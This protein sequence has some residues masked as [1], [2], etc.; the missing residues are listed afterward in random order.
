[1]LAIP[2]VVGITAGPTTPATTNLGNTG[3]T[4]NT[5]DPYN[6][7][8]NNNLLQGTNNL[9]VNDF[10][11]IAFTVR[12]NIDSDGAGGTPAG[13]GSYTNTAT[14]TGDSPSGTPVEDDSQNGPN[15]DPD[16]DDDPTNNDDPTP[17]NITE[18]PILGVAK[19]VGTVTDNGDG[20][21]NVPYI[22]RVQNY[23]NVE[24]SNVQVTDDL[25]N[26][27]VNPTA[28]QPI[29]NVIGGS[30]ASPT[31]TV[32]AGFN[33]TGDNNLL[34]GSDTL[35]VGATAT[36]TFTVRVE[37]NIAQGI[38]DN[39]AFGAGD[40]PGG[41]TVTDTSQD[42]NDPDDNSTDPAVNGDGDPSNNSDPTR[43]TI[44]SDPVIGVAKRV[45]GVDIDTPRWHIP[46]YLRHRRREPRSYSADQRA[47]PRQPQHHLR[48]NTFCQHRDT[49][50]KR[51]T[52]CQRQ[53]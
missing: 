24:L 17:V 8:G 38:Y 31:L 49:H 53:L 16:G 44:P 30:I 5:T 47:S 42:G 11:T 28:P 51:H 33:G 21:Y 13:P 32:N 52:G 48:H 40:S 45:T 46:R 4:I 3:F 19:D 23:G 12:I 2:T 9:A 25:T 20:T 34:D 22:I 14:A 41:T 35:A 27:F 15:P 26:T 43:V 1:M 10:T 7:V 6:G 39:Q 50:R 36:I 29:F 37:P 18:D